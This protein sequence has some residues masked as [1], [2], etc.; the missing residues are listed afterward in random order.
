LQG[1]QS[2][3]SEGTGIGETGQTSEPGRTENGSAERS[4]KNEGASGIGSESVAQ[5]QKTP[6]EVESER[7][8]TYEELRIEQW[9]KTLGVKVVVY[10][11]PS[12]VKSRTVRAEW[13]KGELTPGWFSNGTAYI[14]LPHN[15]GVKS[16]DET[17][18]HEVVSHK[19]IKELLGEEN[20]NKFLDMVWDMMSAESRAE[21]LGYVNGKE[22]SENNRRAAADE[23][24]AHLSEGMS[25]KLGK[26]LSA[27]EKSIWNKIV[28][29]FRNLFASQNQDLADA[30]L[31]KDVLTDKDIKQMIMRSFE[32]LREKAKS[33]EELSRPIQE[34]N[35]TDDLL[36]YAKR[37][38]ERRDML[39]KVYHGSGASFEKEKVSD[40]LGLPYM[41]ERQD[42]NPK[43]VSLAKVIEEFEN[44]KLSEENEETKFKKYKSKDGKETES[45]VSLHW[46][47]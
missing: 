21:F 46:N 17:F 47:G 42:A 40:W 22:E 14:F 45:M 13:A 43:L 44:P 20:F 2:V 26:E 23:Y 25:G 11:D 32:S 24:V 6:E 27:S 37:D 3:P 34:T 39:R 35:D 1:E 33:T 9:E 16:I 7:F 18:V 31:S 10:T 12:Q 15:D 29:V 4:D 36:E 41:E 8:I 5:E 19:G 30:I 38:A 28:D